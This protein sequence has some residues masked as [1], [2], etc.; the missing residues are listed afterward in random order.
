MIKNR[1]LFFD[2]E[3]VQ[4]NATAKILK[5]SYH[6]DIKVVSQ[7]DDFFHE[8]MYNDY[9]ILIM[10]I[11]APLS[12]LENDFVS[13]SK[14]DIKRMDN[15]KSTGIILTEKIW[16]KENYSELPV[17]FYS[18]KD[19]ESFKTIDGKK[20]FYLRKPELAKNIHKELCNLLNSKN[21]Y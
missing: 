4:T 9:D 2:D 14:N 15:G 1:V 20:W 12:F 13:L 21:R 10:D 5:A 17:L 6:W 3:E 7:V 18:S 16:E 19:K 8:L 11:M